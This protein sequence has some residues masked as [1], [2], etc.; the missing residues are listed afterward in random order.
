M[1]IICI[2]ARSMRFF[3]HTNPD[4][5]PHVSVN[6]AAI[7]MTSPLLYAGMPSTW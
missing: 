4:Q 3:A 7:A 5:L 6:S 1:V 2:A